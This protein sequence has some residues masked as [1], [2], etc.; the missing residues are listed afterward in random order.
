MPSTSM[1]LCFRTKYIYS[2]L[3]FKLLDLSTVSEDC[4]TINI[5]RP[6][7]IKSSTKLPVVSVAKPKVFGIRSDI[8]SAAVLDVC[9]LGP[10][11]LRSSN[12]IFLLSSYGGGF[13]IGAANTYNGSQ[14]VERS[15]AR[16]CATSKI[17]H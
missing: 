14:I 15:V 17:L 2:L 10:S 7:G 8:N 3:F 6:K 1:F 4:L 9:I 12:F 5:H 16:V 11:Y 13:V